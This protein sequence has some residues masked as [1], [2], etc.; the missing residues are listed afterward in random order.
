[1][2]LLIGGNVSIGRYLAALLRDRGLPPQ[3]RDAARRPRRRDVGGG[4]LRRSS[5][6]RRSLVTGDR[7][8]ADA[9]AVV[10]LASA[11]VPSTF[12]AEPWREIPPTPSR[13]PASLRGAQSSIRPQSSF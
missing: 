10:H 13:L 7:L 3:D 6:P 5:M 2:I 9:E 8:L 4:G 12:A 1:M 11:S